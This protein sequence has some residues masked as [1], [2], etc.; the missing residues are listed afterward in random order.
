VAGSVIGG[1]MP[2]PVFT[3]TG[4]ADGRRADR[5]GGGAGANTHRGLGHYDPPAG[6]V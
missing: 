6:R 3:L 4:G 1:V 5:A 2:F